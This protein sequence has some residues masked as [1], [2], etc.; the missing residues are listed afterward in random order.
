MRNLVTRLAFVLVLGLAGT[1]AR[2]DDAM[3][4]T[5]MKSGSL[6][7]C[8]KKADMETDAMKKQQMTS[9]CSHGGAMSAMK[10]NAMSAAP[11]P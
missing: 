4:A 7:D 6:A 9:A 5:P 11:K 8:L 2:A 10:P 1:A 3:T